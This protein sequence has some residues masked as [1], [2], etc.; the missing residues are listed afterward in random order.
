MKKIITFLLPLVII[1]C[2]TPIKSIAL[3]HR[4]YLITELNQPLKKEIGDKLILKGEEDYQEAIKIVQVQNFSIS[5]VQFPYTSNDV[6]PYSGVYNDWDLYYDKS[7][8][9]TNYDHIGIAINKKNSQIKPFISSLAG[10]TTKDLKENIKIEK[11]EFS[12]TNCKFC[13]KKEF[14]Y[15]GKVGNN[16]KFIYREFINDMARPAFNQDLQYDL[17]ESNTIGFK[18]LRIEIIKATNTSI[19]YKILSDFAN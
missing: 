3:K 1:S 15:N 11:T 6:L 16:V 10:F 5:T 12:E 7:R 9:Q 17:A 2:A 19:E 14:I 4:T 8:I 18:G 13:F